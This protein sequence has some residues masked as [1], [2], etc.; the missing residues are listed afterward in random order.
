MRS[1]V[2]LYMAISAGAQPCLSSVRKREIELCRN[3]SA[4]HS[5]RYSEPCRIWIG[6]IFGMLAML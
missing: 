2:T 1:M 5:R 6:R 3:R 4:L